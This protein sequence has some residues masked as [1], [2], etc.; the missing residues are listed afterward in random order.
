MKLM[1]Q[2]IE[3]TFLFEWMKS[4]EEL[5]YTLS[6]KSS[7]PRPIRTHVSIDP[8]MFSLQPI[9]KGTLW[10]KFETRT[11]PI[12]RIVRDEIVSIIVKLLTR[13][14]RSKKQK[15]TKLFRILYETSI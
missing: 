7:E 12:K 15:N 11:L 13:I 10:V 2:S 5:I 9:G 4:I 1:K 8:T 14:I 3:A 6:L